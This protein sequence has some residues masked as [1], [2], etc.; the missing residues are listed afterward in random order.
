MKTGNLQLLLLLFALTILNCK[1]DHL[2]NNLM[3][4]DYKGSYKNIEFG[5][6]LIGD[7]LPGIYE[8]K[9]IPEDLKQLS[10]GRI[11]INFRYNG[12]GQIYFMPLLYYG[13]INKND[14]DNAIEEPVF[15]MA[16][17]IGHYN[18][19]PVP[20]EFLFYTICTFNYPQYCRDTYIPITSGENYS[21]IIDKRP[22]GMILQLKQGDS[23]LNIFPHAYFPDSA[24]M[25]FKDV[26]DYTSRYKGDSLKNVLMVGKG[27]AGVENG[28][29]IFNGKISSVRIFKYTLSDKAPEYEIQKV[30]NQQIENEQIQ[31]IIKDNLHGD[32]KMVQMNYEFWPYKYENGVLIPNG[33]KKSGETE[34]QPNNK[35]LSN[36]LNSNDIGFYKINLQTFDKEGNILGSTAQPFEIWIYPKEWDFEFY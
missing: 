36:I 30:R 15:H 17:E 12:G 32:D 28:L 25:F 14:T 9:D 34:K 6:S 8:E 35:T 21:V 5:E 26:T 20:V 16:I 18:V 4:S 2:E 31:Y 19:I 11:E 3:I 27:F 29:H 1:K 10:Y 33:L 13:S 22:E 7:Y 23:I 24:Q